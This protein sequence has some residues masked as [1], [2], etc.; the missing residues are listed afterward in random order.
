MI[1]FKLIGSNNPILNTIEKK[2]KENCVCEIT[3]DTTYDILI[4]A[5]VTEDYGPFFDIV[6]GNEVK[7][8][9]TY[10]FESEAFINY[11]IDTI[12]KR[13]NIESLN[14]DLDIKTADTEENKEI[15]LVANYD[16]I[17]N[18]MSRGKDD[19]E[20][21]LETAK[22]A[23]ASILYV[24]RRAFN[25]PVNEK[26]VGESLNKAIIECDKYA[27]FKVFDN[28]G[29][30]IYSSQKNKININNMKRNIMEKEY[31]FIRTNNG[32][33]NIEN[34]FIPNGT[35]VIINKKSD[36]KS[37]II[38]HLDDKQIKGEVINSILSSM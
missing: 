2:L 35:Q 1:R 17:N 30:V 3:N 19:A 20:V 28:T 36:K 32:G 9:T 29:K 11:I 27:G 16:K 7:I 6:N 5:Q 26:Y 4:D 21:S 38:I 8:T 25:N 13:F 34:T 33:I 23:Y 15:S 31:A 10:K 18:I 37:E 22:R 24:V 14:F 12:F